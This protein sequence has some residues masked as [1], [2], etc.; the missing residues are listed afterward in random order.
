MQKTPLPSPVI[1][2]LVLMVLSIDAQ[3]AQTL[4]EAKPVESTLAAN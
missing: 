1:G 3:I 4:W 2:R